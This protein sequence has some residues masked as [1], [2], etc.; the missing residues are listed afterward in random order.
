MRWSY[1]HTFMYERSVLACL[2]F[3]ISRLLPPVVRF[4]FETKS[5]IRW[6]KLVIQLW[7]DTTL[8]IDYIFIRIISFRWPCVCILWCLLGIFWYKVWNLKKVWHARN[9][10]VFLKTFPS[11]KCPTTSRWAPS[12]ENTD[13]FCHIYT[14]YIYIYMQNTMIALR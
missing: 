3:Q 11:S 9:D 5:L 2:T 7:I 10:R 12:W 13:D 1:I 8:V 6:V 4:M 14:I